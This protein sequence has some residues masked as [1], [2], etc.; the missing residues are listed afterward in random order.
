M[1]DPDRCRRC[2]APL[3]TVGTAPLG[4]HWLRDEDSRPGSFSGK[5]C[6]ECGWNNLTAL[7]HFYEIDLA[8]VAS[9][10]HLDSLDLSDTDDRGHIL[11]QTRLARAAVGSTIRNLVLENPSW[12]IAWL[13]AMTAG[14][15]AKRST[16]DANRVLALQQIYA[17]LL[18][19]GP[20]DLS[21]FTGGTL[22]PDLW[23]QKI[24]RLVQ[25]MSRLSG[26]ILELGAT[27]ASGA[28][29]TSGTLRLIPSADLLWMAE[30]NL[31]RLEDPDRQ[32]HRDLLQAVDEIEDLVYGTSARG[33]LLQLIGSEETASIARAT[34]IPGVLVVDLQSP[35]PRAEL[36]NRYMVLTV[37]RWRSHTVPSFFFA[38][39]RRVHRT[40]QALLVQASSVNWLGFAPLL[41]AQRDGASIGVTSLGLVSQAYG[42]AVAATSSRLHLASNLGGVDSRPDIPAI[43]AKARDVHSEFERAA[44]A[45][46]TAGGVPSMSGVEFMNGKRLPCGEIDLL[47]GCV[48]PRGPVLL[49]GECKNFD[50]TFFKDLGADQARNTI[51]RAANQVIRKRRWVGLNWLKFARVLQLPGVEPDVLAVIVTR[52]I[53]AP[54][55]Q[56]GVPVLAIAELSSLA[57]MVATSPPDRWRRHVLRGMV[58]VAEI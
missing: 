53:A 28:S 42:Q 56:D 40:E 29:I 21:R 14:V 38:D 16:E 34:D 18:S 7:E 44:A 26:A 33:M 49:V 2:Q 22:A 9:Q 39:L 20:I 31:S 43:R 15:G 3:Q 10:F 37:E 46:C 17:C 52:T 27:T 45:E 47:G 55:E 8:D 5:K 36:L 4:K 35:D 30:V 6:E 12:A 54:S 58:A 24:A 1:I 13:I 19:A 50:F 11:N 25:T 23:L 41:H 32:Y 51:R 48:G 57:T